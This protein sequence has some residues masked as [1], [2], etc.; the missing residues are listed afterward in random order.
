M[1]SEPSLM[2]QGQHFAF[3]FER[4]RVLQPQG[5]V[6]WPPSPACRT[7]FDPKVFALESWE[8][9]MQKLAVRTKQS[10]PRDLASVQILCCSPTTAL[11]DQN[12]DHIMSYRAVADG[13][14]R[15]HHTGGIKTNPC[16]HP[17]YQQMNRKTADSSASDVSASGHSDNSNKSKG[18]ATG[19]AKAFSKMILKSRPSTAK[20]PTEGNF[21]KFQI[22]HTPDRSPVEIPP[23]GFPTTN[24]EFDAAISRI[25]AQGRIHGENGSFE[26]E[27]VTAST[28]KGTHQGLYSMRYVMTMF[29]ILSPGY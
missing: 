12:P 3:A 19:A 15:M 22:V 1:L 9:P 25:N 27:D 16:V 11:V 13:T 14:W 10:Y 8:L 5:R 6:T 29:D 17:Q 7:L 26:Q 23:S 2:W 28:R 4:R 21:P 24:E 18:I 20:S